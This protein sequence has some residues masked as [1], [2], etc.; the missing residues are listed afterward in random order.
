VAGPIRD[1]VAQEWGLAPGIPVFVGGGDVPASQAGSG[2]VRPG[3]VHVS[4]GTAIY[5]GICL[6]KPGRDPARRLG[7]LGHMDPNLCILW[8]EIATGGAAL[9]WL[10]RTLGL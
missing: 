6:E 10:G 8:L 4:L 9:A 2:A 3:D 1:T 5:F 7:V